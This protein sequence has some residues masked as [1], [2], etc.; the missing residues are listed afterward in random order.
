MKNSHLAPVWVYILAAALCLIAILEMPYGYYMILRWLVSLAALSILI[1]CFSV[2][3]NSWAW[4]F[5]ILL[6]AFNPISKIN[7]GRE[8]WRVIDGASGA[9]F[10]GF[11]VALKPRNSRSDQ[12]ASSDHH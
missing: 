3:K 4:V 9:A 1:P 8:I 10:I 6:V 2:G 12:A 7:F 11:V 5:L